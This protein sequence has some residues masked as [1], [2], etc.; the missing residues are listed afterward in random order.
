MSRSLLISVRFHEGR[1]HGQQDGFNKAL[2]WPPSPARL[3]QALVASAALGAEL[4]LTDIQ[5]LK[6][7]EKLDAPVIAA[8]WMR[9]G[10]TVKLYVPNNDMDAVDGDPARVAETKVAKQWRPGF[11]DPEVPLYYLWNFE[12][13]VDEATQ[14]CKIAEKL[15]QLGRTYDIAWAEGKILNNDQSLQIFE[16]YRG[17]VRTPRG[18][19]TTPIPHSGTLDSL[20]LRYRRKRERLRTDID[21][22]KAIQLFTQP[23]KASFG[24]VGYDTPAHRLH[25]ELRTESGD[26]APRP[27]AHAASLVES[28][29]K[30]ASE[31]LQNALPQQS[32]LLER[33]IVGKGAG[34]LDIPMRI[35]LL[36]VPSIGTMHTDRSIRRVMVEIPSD[37]PIRL[38]DLRWAFSSIEPFAPSTGEVW[39][40]SLVSTEDSRMAD[41]FMRPS[42]VLQSITPVALPEAPR[43]H[44]HTSK[45]KAG[46]ARAEEHMRNSH[47]LIQALRHA[48]IRQVPTNIRTQKEPFHTRGVSAVEFARGSRFSKNSLWHVEM[49]FA[50]PVNGPVV[51]GDGRFTG[52]GLFEPVLKRAQSAFVFNIEVPRPLDQSA[53]LELLRH[54]RRALMSISRD[55][56]GQVGQIFSGH[57]TDGDAA[58]SGTHQHVFLSSDGIGSPHAIRLI[59]AAPWACDR[60][61]KTSDSACREFAN[62]VCQLDDLR[63]GSIGRFSNLQ[64]VA[65]EEQDPT[66]GP[67]R[68]WA[69]RTPYL[70][71]R[72]L[73]RKDDSL[74]AIQADF[75][76]ECNRRRLPKP[77]Y[78]EVSN[79]TV[80]PRGGRPAAELKVRFATAVRGPIMLGRDSHLGGGLFHMNRQHRQAGSWQRREM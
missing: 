15:F 17:T 73:K 65:L 12:N 68:L 80:G 53:R 33:L 74:T 77:K 6:W 71:T 61:T 43:R 76:T 29:K 51:I 9:L 3:F 55:M 31:R 70:C 64:A 52:L 66:I 67:S 44:S 26:F 41:R 79:L 13:G 11:F 36:P 78:I 50:E 54:L 21:G 24:F 16:Q 42:R 25:F 32:A 59:V 57:G 75:A 46:E 18:M 62:I 5:A 19:G 27:L 34:P 63:A 10:R 1:Y 72:N 58:R 60:S 4:K 2:G 38:D 23:P 48:G 49:Q 47:A 28:L 22:R 40:G 8:P 30:S 39:P 56:S 45:T 14:V 37:C 7:M 20:M 69:S 35:R